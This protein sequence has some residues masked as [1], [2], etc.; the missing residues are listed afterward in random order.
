M[1]SHKMTPRCFYIRLSQYP[2]DCWLSIFVN[3]GKLLSQCRS[4]AEPYWLRCR[5]LWSTIKVHRRVRWEMIRNFQL[6]ILYHCDYGYVTLDWRVHCP[7]TF[8]PS[9][10][11]FYIHALWNLDSCLL[12]MSPMIHSISAT[13]SASIRLSCF[14]TVSHFGI[15]SKAE[16]QV[17]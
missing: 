17:S 15:Y 16:Y 8:L 6:L 4:R 3:V 14:V 13:R 7:N 12:T 1:Y 9:G 10:I 11:N 2:E 5:R